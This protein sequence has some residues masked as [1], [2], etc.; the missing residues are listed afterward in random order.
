MGFS[1]G[2]LNDEEPASS[3]SNPESS[4]NASEDLLIR[5]TPLAISDYYKDHKRQNKET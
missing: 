4:S 3:H 2:I 5:G 1:R